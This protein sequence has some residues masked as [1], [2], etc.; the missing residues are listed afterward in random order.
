MLISRVLAILAAVLLLNSGPALADG[1]Q[2]R[3][4]QTTQVLLMSAHEALSPPRN[5]PALRSAIGSAF[6]FD[7]W[8]RFL[9]KG[10]ENAFSRAQAQEFRALLPGFMAHLYGKQFERGLDQPP[11]IGD[12]RTARRGDILVASQFPRT[13]GRN[14]PVDWRLREF[15]NLGMRVIDVMVGGASFVLLK[16]DEFRV[17]IDRGG[18]EAVLGHMRANSL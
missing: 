1:K 5:G 4:I 12:A 13:N 9:I 18:A 8:G 3:A 11:A 7:V 2:D 15:P 14:L 16:R 17:M 10:R 6:H